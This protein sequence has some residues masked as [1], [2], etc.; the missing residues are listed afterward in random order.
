M[1]ARTM[2]ACALAT[3]TL[4]ARDGSI[5][6]IG[7]QMKRAAVAQVPVG[8]QQAVVLRGA[9]AEPRAGEP[10]DDLLPANGEQLAHQLQPVM[11]SGRPGCGPVRYCG[12]KGLRIQRIGNLSAIFR[13]S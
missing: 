9:V 13:V 1:T 10:W 6:Q 5:R 4:A 12:L 3:C 2:T 8:P 7:Q 11:S